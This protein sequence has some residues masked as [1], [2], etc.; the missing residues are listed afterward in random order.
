LTKKHVLA[1]FWRAVRVISHRG[2][3]GLDKLAQGHYRLAKGLFQ[4][5]LRWEEQHARNPLLV[6][7]MGKV[8]S[9]SVVESLKAAGWSGPVYQFHGINPQKHAREEWLYRRNFR[10]DPQRPRHLWISQY[11]AERLAQ[12]APPNRPWKVVTLVR[13]PVARNLSSFFQI[14]E[15]ELD[16]AASTSRRL[17]NRKNIHELSQLFLEQ[18]D[19]HDDP[20]E[21][22][23]V[24]FKPAFGIDVYASAFPK[25]QGYR[26]YSNEHTQVLVLKLEHLEHCAQDAFRRLLG[27]KNFRLMSANVA[28]VKSVGPIYQQ[29]IS[30]IVLPDE[31]L[32]RMYSS[33]YA[34]H[35]YSKAELESFRSRWQ[36]AG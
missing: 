15:L 30:S 5:R 22:F 34:Q 12:P 31:Y 14:L 33:R 9:T 16:W 18:V 13:D 2:W 19:W 6:Y 25:A 20:L 23:D 4:F 3:R 27:L 1:L 28:R 11:F 36:R 10:H 24:E 32:D 8:G 35:F 7:Q 17:T 26:T 21:W 29:F